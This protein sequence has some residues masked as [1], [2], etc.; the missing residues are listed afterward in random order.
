MNP[1][2]LGGRN[3]NGPTACTGAPAGFP[4][5]QLLYKRHVKNASVQNCVLRGNPG[6]AFAVSF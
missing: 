5:P 3:Y 4:Y 1:L 2:R 6:S